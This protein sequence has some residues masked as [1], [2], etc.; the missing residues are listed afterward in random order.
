VLI[1]LLTVSGIRVGEVIRSGVKDLDLATGTLTV[2]TAYR[3]HAVSTDSPLPMLEAEKA[4]RAH[5]IVEQVIATWKAGRSRTCRQG[6]SG[7]TAPGWSAPR[8]PSTS[9]A[10]PAPWPRPSTPKP[11]PAPS[12]PNSSPSPVGSHAPPAG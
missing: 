11:P 1:G 3:Y 2:F 5:A 12:A 8:S 6:T 4:R 9:P 7:P 10:P